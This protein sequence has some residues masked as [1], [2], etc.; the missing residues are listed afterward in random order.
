MIYEI[1]V[2]SNDNLNYILSS[3]NSATFVDG[4]LSN[5]STIK[6]NLMMANSAT[7]SNLNKYCAELLY[8]NTNL[9]TIFVS[10]KISPMYFLKYSSGMKYDYHVDTNPIGGVNAHYSMTC[11]LSDPDE[12]TGGELV[13]QIGN[14]EI[15]YKLNKGKALVYSTGIKHKVNP[16]LSGDRKVFV[17]WIESAIKNSFIRNYLI[18]YGNLINEIEISDDKIV[19]GQNLIDNLEQFR[20][21]LMREYGDL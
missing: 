1:D 15:E 17:C 3:F 14:K 21:N 19:G 4:S 7:Y 18:D 20:I 2:L 5:P 10:K 16:V 12:Y 13:L 6:K 11:F 8:N 9:Y